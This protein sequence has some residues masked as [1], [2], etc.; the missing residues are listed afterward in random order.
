MP[1]PPGPD[2]GQLTV[3]DRWRICAGASRKTEFPL[4][5]DRTVL[6]QR[7]LAHA[8]VF[9]DRTVTTRERCNRGGAI[10]SP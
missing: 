8:G 2:P 6:L 3:T 4:G 9:Q 5:N 10:W 7:C 1:P